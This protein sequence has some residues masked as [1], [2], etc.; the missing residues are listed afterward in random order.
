MGR[1]SI[2]LK[3]I[4]N[5]ITRLAK[6]TVPPSA[7]VNALL[8]ANGSTPIE[9]GA[10]LS[11]LLRRPEITYSAL[12]PIDEA[13]PALDAAVCETVEVSVKYEGYIR[14]EEAEVARQAKLEEKR[15]SPDLDYNAIKG[16]RLEAAEKLSAVRPLN[17][18]QA[19]R[20]SGVNPA[21]ITVLLI[22]LRDR[23]E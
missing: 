2:I 6:T 21:D 16:L 10:R 12:A 15:L 7:A 4:Q 14:R 8:T 13:R 17:I 5:E 19:S 18:A 11:D 3:T 9:S 20:I 1:S 22:W 23:K